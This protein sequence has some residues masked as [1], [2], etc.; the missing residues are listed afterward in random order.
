MSR[1]STLHKGDFAISAHSV[2]I[3]GNVI[4]VFKGKWTAHANGRAL[5]KCPEGSDVDGSQMMCVIKLRRPMTLE[6]YREA[7]HPD[8]RPLIKSHD[9]NIEAVLMPVEMAQTI[10]WGM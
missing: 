1:T 2:F 5:I 6:E 7:H 4:D 3:S 10:P 9:A 8:I